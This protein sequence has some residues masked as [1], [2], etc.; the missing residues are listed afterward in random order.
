[1]VV[2]KQL[3]KKTDKEEKFFA[4]VWLN[5][6]LPFRLKVC[7]NLKSPINWNK[8]NPFNFS[9]A[10]LARVNGKVNKNLPPIAKIT[11][12]N[13]NPIKNKNL[14]PLEIFF[15]EILL[16]NLNSKQKIANINTV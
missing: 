7:N 4:D 15:D 6:N 9:K 14:K 16:I 11:A 8:D 1:M 3:R 12:R 13:N 5:E 10:R 2:F